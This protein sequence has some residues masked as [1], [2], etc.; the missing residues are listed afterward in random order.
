MQLSTIIKLITVSG[1][2]MLVKILFL[3][4]NQLLTSKSIIR[5]T[6]NVVLTVGTITSK[7]FDDVKSLF[8]NSPN[9]GADFTADLVLDT[10]LT[11]WW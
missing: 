8:M 1:T 4:H 6:G 2:L 10:T 5:N 3:L 9:T 7:N 11:L